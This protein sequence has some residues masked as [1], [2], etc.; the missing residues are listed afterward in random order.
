MHYAQFISNNGIQAQLFENIPYL[1]KFTLQG[2]LK[3]RVS[4]KPTYQK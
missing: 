4:K 1:N 2:F 3:Y